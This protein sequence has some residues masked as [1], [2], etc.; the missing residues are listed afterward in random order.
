MIYQHKDSFIPAKFHIHKAEVT[1]ETIC[2]VPQRERFVFCVFL[3][4]RGT[5]SIKKFIEFLFPHHS[6][7]F[8]PWSIGF[9]PTI[10]M[11]ITDK[12]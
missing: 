9:S 7:K 6:V 11:Q 12:I 8:C 2:G 1:I 3:Q 4:A 10:N 5:D